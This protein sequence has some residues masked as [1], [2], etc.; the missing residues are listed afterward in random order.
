MPESCPPSG[1][2]PREL[3]R[4]RQPCLF[5]GLGQDFRGVDPLLDE[6][7]REF[8]HGDPV[9]LGH[10]TVELLGDCCLKRVLE[11]H[12]SSEFL[13]LIA[14]LVFVLLPPIRFQF[15]GT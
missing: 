13:D 9:L 8:H 7:V 14:G 2:W 3:R 4:T 12:Q 5:K 10:R 1:G 6:F 11:P 15:R